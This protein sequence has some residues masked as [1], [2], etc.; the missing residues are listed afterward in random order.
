MIPGATASTAPSVIKFAVGKG[1]LGDVVFDGRYLWIASARNATPQL[2]QFDPVTNTSVANFPITGQITALTYDGT[3][4][5]VTS[6]GVSNQFDPVQGKVVRQLSTQA[7]LTL[8]NGSTID[9]FSSQAVSYRACDL[10]PLRNR[11]LPGTAT[12][13]ALADGRYAVIYGN[14]TVSLR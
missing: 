1:G 6:S 4:L 12:G 5:W 14:N 10:A 11:A 8:V 9:G 2:Y 7:S 3:F 13:A